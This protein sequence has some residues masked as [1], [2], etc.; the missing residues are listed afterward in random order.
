MKEILFQQKYFSQLYVAD[1]G[2]RLVEW[3]VEFSGLISLSHTVS[4]DICTDNY[5]LGIIHLNEKSDQW[6]CKHKEQIQKE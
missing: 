6:H 5:V 4:H 3:A 1:P 2:E